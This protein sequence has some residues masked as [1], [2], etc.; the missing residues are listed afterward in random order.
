MEGRGHLNE[1]VPLLNGGAKSFLLLDLII[2]SS[3]LPLGVSHLESKT[4]LRRQ[5][6][7]MKGPKDRDDGELLNHP[8]PGFSLFLHFSSHMIQILFKLIGIGFL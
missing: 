6:G 8:T 2:T 5:V 7:E 1:A 3:I 4:V